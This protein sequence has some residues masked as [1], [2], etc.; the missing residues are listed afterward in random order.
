MFFP[1]ETQIIVL[2]LFF[3]TCLFCNNTKRETKG[4]SEVWTK[5]HFSGDF[6]KLEIYLNFYDV[7]GF[8]LPRCFFYCQLRTSHNSSAFRMRRQLRYCRRRENLW[9]QRRLHRWKRRERL[10]SVR[11]WKWRCVRLDRHQHGTVPVDL[12]VGWVFEV[13]ECVVQK[14]RVLH[15]FIKF[16]LNVKGAMLSCESIGLSQSLFLSA[17]KLSAG[18]GPRVD[19]DAGS[20]LGHYFAVE[21]Y[22]GTLNAPARLN[23]AT[24]RDSASTCVMR[25]DDFARFRTFALFLLVTISPCFRR[26]YIIS[27]IELHIY[28]LT[29]CISDSIITWKI[30][31]LA[32]IV[33]VLLR[34]SIVRMARAT[35][36]T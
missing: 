8:I 3:I 18:D 17:A 36:N 21:P 25:Q 23:S 6:A 7:N 27:S 32:G 15:T 11:L 12:A 24:M 14:F 28:I 2:L 4:T 1:S 29:K 30:W 9:L 20:G 22:T 26:V 13:G 5:V 10:W 34:T 35:A 16:G 31:T 19:H 33:P